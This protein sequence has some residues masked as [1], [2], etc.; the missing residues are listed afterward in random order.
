M[1]QVK[2][3]MKPRFKKNESGYHESA[4]KILASWV[5]GEVEKPFCFEGKMIFVPDVACY[6]NGVIECIY[7][8]VHAHPLT[9]EK[10]GRIQEWCYRNYTDLTVFEISADFILSQT[11]KPERIETMECYVVSLF[12]YEEENLIKSIS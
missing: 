8:V 11:C 5:N 4:V 7:E 3:M 9:G 1:N 12:E 10:Y 6:K 2:V